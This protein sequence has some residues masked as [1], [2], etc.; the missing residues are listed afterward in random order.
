MQFVTN[1]DA[2]LSRL[3]PGPIAIQE[4]G[5]AGRLFVDGNLEGNALL[6][7]FL[8]DKPD[9][10][11]PVYLDVRIAG[12]DYRYLLSGRD[13]TN[14]MVKSPVLTPDASIADGLEI[15]GINPLVSVFC[16]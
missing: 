9:E 16:S 7:R 10:I 12:K 5:I 8:F 6:F 4:N 14:P 13:L 15:M 11:V 1:H 2:I 3:L